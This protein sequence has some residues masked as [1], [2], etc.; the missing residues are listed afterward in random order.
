M[1]YE[2]VEGSKLDHHSRS[3][4]LCFVCLKAGHS[5]LDHIRHCKCQ[6]NDGIKDSLKVHIKNMDAVKKDSQSEESVESFYDGLQFVVSH[7]S[8]LGL[9]LPRRITDAYG[10]SHSTARRQRGSPSEADYGKK[11]PRARSPS[12]SSRTS[13]VKSTGAKRPKQL[14][15]SDI[16]P[17][18]WAEYRQLLDRNKLFNI[19][20]SDA[21]KA[22]VRFDVMVSTA[23]G[24][25]RT[26]SREKKGDGKDTIKP[27]RQKPPRRRDTRRFQK[28]D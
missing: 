24:F 7:A 23:L 22:N 11:K 10:V 13:T 19:S 8:S 17:R 12:T 26:K 21:I 15:G 5:G 16:V 1:V 20:E 14:A 3:D 25:L 27:T 2:T 4:D 9:V 6:A 18:P 28:K